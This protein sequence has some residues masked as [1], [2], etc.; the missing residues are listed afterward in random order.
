[1][2]LCWSK[3]NKKI[4]VTGNLENATALLFIIEKVKE[5]VLDFSTRNCKSIVVLFCFNIILI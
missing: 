2:H 1:M 4:N 5:T 3:S